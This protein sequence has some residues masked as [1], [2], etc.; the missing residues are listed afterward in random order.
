MTANRS[1]LANDTL[2]AF[3][4]RALAQADPHGPTR[5][6]R[7]FRA[8]PRNHLGLFA[9]C[10]LVDRGDAMCMSQRPNTRSASSRA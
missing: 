1:S 10:A 4:H 2:I 7:Q 5:R 6:F 9:H 3:A 8:L